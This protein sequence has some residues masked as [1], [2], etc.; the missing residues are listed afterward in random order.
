MTNH[1]AAAIRRP[2]PRKVSAF[3]RRPE[4][5]SPETLTKRSPAGRASGAGVGAGIGC[6]IGART[7]AAAG[8]G[9]GR[10]AGACVTG[11]VATAVDV[12]DAYS[13]AAD[14]AIEMRG[15]ADSGGADRAGSAIEMRG[16]AR[17]P[18]CE[19][20]VVRSTGAGGETLG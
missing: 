17:D 5:R 10:G 13:A 15:G 11:R 2:R 14:A 8:V 16:A 6:G 9:A 20:G 19:S 7:G 4:S 1:A 18:A 12:A 3:E